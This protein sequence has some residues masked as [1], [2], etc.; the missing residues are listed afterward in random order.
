MKHVT[1]RDFVKN[2]A[3]TG[4][5]LA[6]FNILGAQSSNGVHTGKIKVGL[7]GCGGRGNGALS[8]F[9]EAAKMLGI[10]VEVVAV[11]DAF[12]NSAK[13]VANRYQVHHSRAHHGF[14]A[15]KEVANS[16]AEV[17]LMATPPSFRPLHF[18]A[19]VQAG[20][21][22]FIEKPVAVDPVGARQ[23]IATGELAR[24]KG[25]TVVAGTQRRHTKGY[26]EMIAKLQSGAI[27]EIVGGSVSWNMGILWMAERKPGMSN[28]DF[29]AKNWLNFTELSGDH[30]VEQ[31][32]HQLDVTNWVMG[33]MPKSFIG[34]GGCARRAI[35]GG[36]QFDFFSVDMDYGD[37]IHIHSQCRQ[38]NGCYNRVSESFR[39][40]KGHTS[41]TRV[42]GEDVRTEA[43]G[44]MHDSGM[45]QE[46]VDLLRSIRGKGEPLNR[47]REVADATMCAIGERIAAYTGKLVRWVD[48]TENTNSAFYNLSL[49]PSA[50][51]FEKGEVAMPDESPAVPGAEKA[52][53][54]RA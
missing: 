6:A 42:M 26:L 37:G 54:V 20:K 28:A 30:I 29:L 12:E 2:A 51:D 47:S 9:I 5:G 19:C 14:S 48:L 15:Y 16:D 13:G 40:T 38:I 46:H 18:E 3:V 53:K 41:G 24:Q 23:V 45:I 35:T 50:L 4:A 31:H 44:V 27:G 11:A 1:R 52:W 8:N 36:N 34:F 21:H 7:I 43:I 39:G 33:R 32:V 22:C 49:A 10:S 25:L 17:V